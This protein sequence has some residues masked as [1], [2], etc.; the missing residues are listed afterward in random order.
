MTGVVDEVERRRL[1]AGLSQ[2]AVAAR[3]GIT[4][5]HYSKVVGGVV[6]LTESLTALMTDWLNANPAPAMLSSD[7][8]RQIRELSR[9]I[10]RDIRRL[11][12]LLSAEGRG[13]SRRAPQRTSGRGRR[14][15]P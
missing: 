7:S 14:E 10:E 5:S 4:Q 1:D 8:S 6:T 2:K 9:S 3:L 13:P 11:N 15:R 12:N